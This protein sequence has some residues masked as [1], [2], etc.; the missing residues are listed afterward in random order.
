MGM[1]VRTLFS[2][3]L[4][5][6]LAACGE[7][8]PPLPPLPTDATILA[9]GDSLTYGSGAA[10]EH[11]YPSVLEELSGR[12]VINAGVPGELSA[13]GLRRLPELL[14]E[15]QPQLL[16][17]CHGGNDMLRKS[18]MDTMQANLERMIASSHERGI[19]VVLL[20]VPRPALFGLESA[21]PYAA[22]A[23]KLKLPFESKIIPEVL[24]ERTLK[25]DQVHP[26]AAGYRM[27]GEAVYQILRKAGAL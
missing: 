1:I 11:S 4:L 19:P 12:T 24:S 6:L 22:V 9:F 23:K 17:L 25:S 26:N 13:T 2:A 14:D 20:G 7:S 3:L 10:R 15:Y 8:V 5:L 18:G 27:M 21:E 16:V